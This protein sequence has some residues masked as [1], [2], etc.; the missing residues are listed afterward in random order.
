MNDRATLGR[1]AHD[2]PEVCESSGQ[3]FFWAFR[4]IA[5]FEADVGAAGGFRQDVNG[6]SCRASVGIGIVIRG[7]DLEADPKRAIE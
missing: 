4:R 7:R 1:V 6:G 3:R 5:P 2:R